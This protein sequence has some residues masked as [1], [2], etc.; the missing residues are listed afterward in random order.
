MKL[1]ALNLGGGGAGNGSGTLTGGGTIATG[2]FTLTVG[3]TGT[4]AL[5]GTAQTYSAAKTFSVAGAASTPAVNLTGTIFT[6]GSATTTKPQL[7]IEPTG[8]TSTGWSTSGTGL[9]VNAASG[10]T[11]NLLDLQVAATSKFSVTS[12]GA[13]SAASINLNF[14]NLTL[15][16]A[17]NFYNDI[18]ASNFVSIYG[19]GGLIFTTGVSTRLTS[20]ANIFQF[21][22]PSASPVTQ[23]LGGAQGVGSNIT[24]GT[25]NIGTRGTGTGTGGIINFQSHAAGASSSTLGTL[26]TVLS[27][28]SST[29][30]TVASGVSLKLGNAATTGLGAGVLAALTNASIVLTDST[31]QAYRIP[32]II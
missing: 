16:G 11:G 32:C 12:A 2:G 18:S 4:A 31:G 23:T 19:Y 27:I 9:G 3:A 10:F 21:G 28:S 15:G 26:A 24:G 17:A 25:L 5:L 20:D 6:G 13:V 30:I 1:Y 8:T 29:L 22:T 7:L 14:G